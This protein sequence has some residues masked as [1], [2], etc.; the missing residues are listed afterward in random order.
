MSAKSSQMNIGVF[1]M[2]TGNHFSGWRLPGSIVSAEDLPAITRLAQDAERAKYDFVFF[3]D[4][5]SCIPTNHPSYVLKL[6][7]TTLLAALAT[8]TSRIGLVAT[9]SSTLTEPY[10]CARLFASVD[11]IS[12]GRGGWNVVTTGATEAYANYGVE[13]PLHDD[14]YEIAAEYLEVVQGLWDSW[15]PGALKADRET[16]EYFD[17]EKLHYL[18]HKGKHFQVQGPLSHSR[19]PQ[20]QPVIVQ[21]GSSDAGQA[22][23]AKYAEV[24]FTIQQDIEEAKAFRKGLKAKVA[25][26]GR[27]PDH[28]KILPGLFPV[29][30][31]TEE[32]AKAKFEELCR[33]I[34]PGSA[35]TVMNARYGHDMSIYPMD[36]PVPELPISQALQSFATV[37]LAKAR[38]ENLTMKQLHDLFALSRGYILGVGTGA[39]VADQMAEW[40]TAG[41]CDGFMI[42]PANFPAALDDFTEMVL[43]ELRKRGLFREDYEGTTF[44]SHLGLPEPRNRY[45]K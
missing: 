29:V 41:A 14:R 30:G 16:G 40:F 28:C 7:P 19:S 4:A 6:E 21:A 13:R 31:R 10:N 43:P 24:V 1:V 5:A 3:A 39:Q 12:G 34:E 17:R 44:R 11:T 15:E 2:A 38:R 23:A 20:G 25:A 45:V 35:M 37:L 32:E 18:N 8:Q 22:F 42:T 9:L 33:F 36:G 27:N 26:V